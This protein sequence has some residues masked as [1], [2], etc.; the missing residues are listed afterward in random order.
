MG[1]N[2]DRF[3]AGQFER[4]KCPVCHDVVKDPVAT[5][6]C[7]HMFC[8]SCLV[9]GPCPLCRTNI[10]KTKPINH[11]LNEFYE[12]LKLKC[13]STGCSQELTIAN[14]KSHEAECGK[15]ET[16][17]FR[18]KDSPGHNCI[19]NLQKR[20]RV[21]ENRLKSIELDKSKLLTRNKELMD[22]IIGARKGTSCKKKIPNFE[23][24]LYCSD[25]QAVCFNCA[26]TCGHPI[27]SGIRQGKGHEGVCYTVSLTGPPLECGC[28]CEY[29]LSRSR[30]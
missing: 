29:T 28:Q 11:V 6:P 19:K 10:I 1:I 7:D 21:L 24:Y 4:F 18:E 13:S 2:S 26:R 9:L 16:C 30:K 15:C 27:K 22:R 25:C 5:D 23:A 8:R 14:Y 3:I 20:N 12:S 17:G